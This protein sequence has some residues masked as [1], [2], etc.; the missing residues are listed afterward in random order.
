MRGDAWRISGCVD[1]AGPLF[2]DLGRR[3]AKA[4]QASSDQTG[5]DRKGGADSL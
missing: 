4:D 5:D 2:D 3:G 1:V